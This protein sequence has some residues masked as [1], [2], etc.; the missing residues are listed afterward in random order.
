MLM[1]VGDAMLIDISKCQDWL[2][3]TTMLDIWVHVINPLAVTKFIETLLYPRGKNLFLFW[4]IVDTK[5][6]E[7]LT[8]WFIATCSN[9]IGP[10]LSYTLDICSPEYPKIWKHFLSST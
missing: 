2:V 4:S 9:P 6:F 5:G 3:G 1:F 7:P 8:L 10:T